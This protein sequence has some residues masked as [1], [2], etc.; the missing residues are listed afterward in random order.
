MISTSST[1]SPERRCRLEAPASRRMRRAGGFSLIELMIAIVLGLLVLAGLINLFV[2]NN[3]AFQIQSGNSYLQENL[4]IAS[5]RISWSL[6]MADFWGGNEAA[7]VGSGGT[8]ANKCNLAWATAINGSSPGAGAVFGYDGSATFGSGSIPLDATTC[9]GGAANYVPG[10][11]V[12]VVRYAYPQMLSPGPLVA[13]VTPAESTTISGAPKTQMFLLATSDGTAQLFPGGGAAPTTSG[14][15]FPRY[16]YPFAVDM[17]YLR[18]CSV[19]AGAACA[20]TDDGG[21]PLPTLMRA[22]LQSDGTVVTAEVV[23]GVEQLQFEYGVTADP[24]NVLPVWQNAA[25]VG[26]QWAN[27]V[28][29]RVAL[30]AVSPTRDV[31]VP[32]AKSYTVGTLPTACTYVINN[33]AAATTAACPNFTPYG[34]KPWQFVRASQLFVAQVRNRIRGVAK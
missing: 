17:Y 24:A 22:H 5:D 12:L 33:Q 32:H 19:M 8:S 11:D 9:I 1:I 34:D 28:A 4:R 16:A 23:D 31:S 30:V 2:A 21:M 20:S 14:S 26:T 13:G 15:Q 18:P 3:K 7:N 6:R 25:G 10:S 29:V 27:V